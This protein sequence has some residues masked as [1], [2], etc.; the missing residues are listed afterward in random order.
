[1]KSLEEDN[2]TGNLRF[3]NNQSYDHRTEDELETKLEIKEIEH[4]AV[5]FK[6]LLEY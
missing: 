6:S 3:V 4:L 1:M 5:E 2:K